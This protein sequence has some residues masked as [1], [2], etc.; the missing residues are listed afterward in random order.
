M[1]FFCFVLGVDLSEESPFRSQPVQ[2]MVVFM[3]SN[4]PCVM[5]AQSLFR[6]AWTNNT[7]FEPAFVSGGGTQHAMSHPTLISFLDNYSFYFYFL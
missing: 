3:A 5:R 4:H 7:Q 2:R 1:V 6:S